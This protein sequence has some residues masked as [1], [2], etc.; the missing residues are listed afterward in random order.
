[1]ACAALLIASLRTS[2]ACLATPGTTT[3]TTTTTVAPNTPCQT[4]AT[5]LIMVTTAGNGAKPMDRDVVDMTG[6]CA[7]RTFT[8]L[9]MNANIEINRF[10]VVADADDGAVDGSATFEVTCNAAGTA[11]QAGGM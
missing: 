1:L 10:G 11:W 3:P 7:T 2:D 8:C 4:C 6:A 9:G 5:T